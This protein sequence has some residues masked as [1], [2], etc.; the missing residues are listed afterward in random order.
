VGCKL[1]LYPGYPMDK[2]RLCA[3]HTSGGTRSGGEQID[4]DKLRVLAGDMNSEQ[5][6]RGRA[7]QSTA[8]SYQLDRH[9][10][11]K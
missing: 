6:E 2:G 4:T 10:T 9:I 3:Q 11:Q 8:P 5:T 7:G 1:S